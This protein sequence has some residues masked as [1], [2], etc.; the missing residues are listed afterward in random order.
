M[1]HRFKIAARIILYAGVF[2]GIVAACRQGPSAAA[3]VE[4]EGVPITF[5]LERAGMVTLVIEDNAGRRVRNLMAETPFEAGTHTVYWDGYDEG[6]A[7]DYQRKQDVGVEYDVL[8]RQ[9]PPG[10]YRVRGLV[11][12]GIKMRYEFSIQSPG[13]PAWHTVDGRGAWLADHT[14]PMDVLFLP[15]GSPYGEGPQLMVSAAVAEAGHALMWLD[16]S[17]RKLYGKK[18][19]W[20]GG[21]ALARDQG[22]SRSDE[23]YAHSVSV[24]KGTELTLFA[25]TP[26]GDHKALFRHRLEATYARESGLSLAVF[27]QFAAI[28]LPLD[29]KILFVEMRGTRRGRLRGEMSIPQPKGLHA[30]RDGA[31][32]VLSGTALKR[33]ELDWRTAELFSEETLTETN[34]D[35]PHALTADA[36][37]RFY[38]SD[39]GERHQVKVF[40]VDGG[41]LRAIGQRGTPRL[42]AYAENQMRRPGGL[43]VDGQGHLWVAELT[44]VP[45]RISRWR[46]D[47]TLDRAFYGPTKYGGGGVIDPRDPTRFYYATGGAKRDAEGVGEKAGIAFGLDWEAGTAIPT[48]IYLQTTGENPVTNLPSMGPEQAVYVDGRR[49]LVN[50]F[51]QA[52]HGMKS[53]VGIWLWEEDETVRLVSVVGYHGRGLNR[54]WLELNQP[55]H[56]AMWPVNAQPN[57]LFYAW[58]DL[59]SDGVVQPEEVKYQIVDRG[60]GLVYVHRDLSV[61]TSWMHGLAAPS[62]R[63]DGVP[64]YDLGT[65]QTLAEVRRADAD[66]MAGEEGWV[67][68]VGGPISGYREGERLWTYHNQWYKRARAAAPTEPGQ[69]VESARVLGYAVTPHAG[70]SGEVWAL[71]SD[72]GAIYLFTTDGLFLQTIGGDVRLKPILRSEE[73]KRGE[74]VEGVSF[75]EEHFWPTIGQVEDDGSIYLAAGKEHTSLFRLEGFD[76]VRRIDLG[77][78]TIAPEGIADLPATQRTPANFQ[79]NQRLTIATPE[80]PPR[81]DGNLDDWA[82]V[83]WIDID[84][85][86]NITAALAFVDDHLFV[87]FRTDE[88]ALLDNSGADGW[89][90]LFATGGGLDLMVRGTTAAQP[91]QRRRRDDG[92]ERPNRPERQRP[93]RQ[94]A[95]VGDVRLFVTREGD[96]LNGPIRA[97]RYQPVGRFGRGQAYTFTSPVGTAAFESVLD[98]STE[99]R[100]AQSGGVYELAVPLALLGLSPDASITTMG[101]VGVLLGNGAETQARLYWNNKTATM[102]SDIPSEARLQP[103]YWGTWA[104][105]E[106]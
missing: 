34:L 23:V 78:V 82:N 40:D 59:N 48:G 38:I 76:T 30:D 55:A 33:L 58:S 24:R 26:D 71:G 73:I 84:K 92:R 22:E 67:I 74:I 72:K 36:E 93:G 8:R 70:Q 66:V 99:V 52:S 60:Q 25:H 95:N 85:R 29:E 96:P 42:G 104:F 17:G 1:T 32:Y 15:E 20:E 89:Q 80:S 44:Y 61:I 83:P 14:P 62:I 102:V 11:H 68:H 57:Q 103:A 19:G 35:A 53:V 50:T 43:A 81:I 45:K 63:A 6:E 87:A 46:A 97:V 7:V 41:Y 28:S 106:Q 27:N 105:E 31:L 54:S 91:R 13:T 37:G 88:P 49:Y 100:L 47:G 2:I 56:Q 90:Y 98:V 5:T 10:T 69:L 101:D 12:D 65:W 94:A 79:Q 18:I 75:D 51:N 64:V 77:T 86:R 16:E 3:A 21:F 39:W 9:A 4:K